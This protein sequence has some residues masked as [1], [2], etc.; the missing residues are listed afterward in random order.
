LFLPFQQAQAQLL[1]GV[2]HIAAHAFL[3]AVG[4]FDL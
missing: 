4:L 3:L 1:L 2:F